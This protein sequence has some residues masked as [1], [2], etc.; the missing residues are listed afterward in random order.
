MRSTQVT[1][2]SLIALLLV[3]TLLAATT[4]VAGGTGV[5]SA[6]TTYE[7]I[8][9][10]LDQ[11]GGGV[12]PLFAVVAVN[13]T[14]C[15]AVSASTCT[16]RAG[17]PILFSLP[18]AT[19]PAYSQSL[20]LC[21]A[22]AWMNL[23]AW[24]DGFGGSGV[25]A[26]AIDAVLSN[27]SVALGGVSNP[28]VRLLSV[29]PVVE[30]FAPI[31]VTF[32]RDASTARESGASVTCSFTSSSTPRLNGLRTRV[33]RALQL[34]GTT[35]QATFVMEQGLE[36]A[37]VSAW[38]LRVLLPCDQRVPAA[39]GTFDVTVAVTWGTTGTPQTDVLV[40]VRCGVPFAASP[41]IPSS[42]FAVTVA[43]YDGTALPEGTFHVVAV[44]I[45]A[46]RIVVGSQPPGFVAPPNATV[47]L[48][49]PYPSVVVNRSAV[50]VQDTGI[51]TVPSSQRAIAGVVT[52]ALNRAYTAIEGSHFAG[53]G[54]NVNNLTFS[55][56]LRDGG[57]AL[58]VSFYS[59]PSAPTVVTTT[60][61]IGSP[62]LTCQVRTCNMPGGSFDAATLIYSA[63]NVTFNDF[64]ANRG[65]DCSYGWTC[66][67]N[68]VAVIMNAAFANPYVASLNGVPFTNL[69]LVSS[70]PRYLMLNSSLAPR[71]GANGPWGLKI[72]LDAERAG[73]FKFDAYPSEWGW[74]ALWF[75]PTASCTV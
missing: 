39:T 11:A 25:Y 26:V 53:M 18:A 3:G 66:P 15:R 35:K 62:M 21:C 41:P 4:P 36:V 33:H 60:N 37:S 45:S 29:A 12:T 54:P 6:C 47:L 44:P 7:C 50:I 14:L 10:A 34:D 63:P 61:T 51:S 17:G 74:L 5:P 49:C 13:A 8:A 32:A 23:T 71:V 72:T 55:P 38:S 64:E 70:A 1:R 67:S 65:A 31:G 40:G 2:K 9:A 68:S 69:S 27:A 42:S 52:L 73:T 46:T 19:D 24:A 59:R 57:N 75:S 58:L 43:R 30:Q 56:P 20:G 48:I 22:L 16:S 28:V